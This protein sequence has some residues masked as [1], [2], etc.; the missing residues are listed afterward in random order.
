[1]ASTGYSE[2]FGNA[3]SDDLVWTVTGSSPL[4]GRYE[5]KQAYIEG[6]TKPILAKLKSPFC[7][8][9]DRI[10]ADGEWAAV[11]FH[12]K[13]VKAANGMNYDLDYCWLMKAVD[14]KIVEVVG[15]YDQRKVKDLFS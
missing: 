6:I 3:L 14:E 9:L 15:F 1:M 2:D 8:I 13:D 7:P 4:A 11:H 5:G 12:S 10:I